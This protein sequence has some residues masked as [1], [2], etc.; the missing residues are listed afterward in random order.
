LTLAR[1]VAAL[2][3]PAL[4]AALLSGASS[5]ARDQARPTCLGARA[6][7]VGTPKAETLRGTQKRDV[8]AALGGADRILGRG[9]NDLLCGGAGNDQLEGGPGRNRID[10]G[11]GRDTCRGATRQSGCEP[12]PPR[13]A[14]PLEGTTLDGRRLTL[15]SFRGRPVLVNVWSSW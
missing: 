11:P 12:E 10:G 5:A 8:I 4:A 1:L 6:T 7:I 13:I 2:S 9:G 15:A 3:V 14:P